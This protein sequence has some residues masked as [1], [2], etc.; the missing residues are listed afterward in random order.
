MR[1]SSEHALEQI[2]N[3]TWTCVDFISDLHLSAQCANTFSLLKTYFEQTPAQAVFILGDLLEV[4]IG[5]DCLDHEAFAFERS[6]VELLHEA[7]LGRPVFFM[8]GNRDFL[9]GERFLKQSGMTALRDPCL[10][11]NQAHRLLL[12]HGDALCLGD[13]DYQTFRQ[14]VRQNTWQS[15]FL[16][17][18][19]Q[20]RLD[21]ALKM[22]A[23]SQEKQ[24]ALPP[25][26]LAELDTQ[27][28]LDWLEKHQA[29][30]LIHGHTHRPMRHELNSTHAREVL[31]DWDAQASPPRA[32]V[33]RLQN[34]QL[35][36]LE[37][38]A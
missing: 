9:A 37:L 35:S 7:S 3:H 17:Q 29:Q 6:C 2:E 24:A 30:L 38:L 32:Q 25:M 16:A 1:F 26:A 15:L 11:L 10:L 27:A 31:S 4:W 18:P 12:S 34:A 8:P 5:D 33:L 36:R 23:Q 13:R 20:E 28:C 19:L 22:R 21:L 14:Q